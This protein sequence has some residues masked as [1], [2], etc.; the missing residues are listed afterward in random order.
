MKNTIRTLLLTI[1][2]GGLSLKYTAP[3]YAL[4]GA[5]PIAGLKL[6]TDMDAN[7]FAITNINR[8]ILITPDGP[9]DVVNL[10][11]GY[12]AMTNTTEFTYLVK[13]TTQNPMQVRVQGGATQQYS[14]GMYTY[15]VDVPGAY[16]EFKTATQGTTIKHPTYNITVGDS[17][18]DMREDKI[19]LAVQ[20][21]TLTL[22]TTKATLKAGGSTV[23]VSDE[24]ASIEAQNTI[25]LTTTANTGAVTITTS[26]LNIQT[27]AQRT[28]DIIGAN[29]DAGVDSKVASQGYARDT[30]VQAVIMAS[31]SVPSLVLVRGNANTGKAAIFRLKDNDIQLRNSDGTGLD[32]S[33]HNAILYGHTGVT[34][35]GGVRDVTIMSDA[36]N[37]MSPTFTVQGIDTDIHAAKKINLG[38]GGSTSNTY[39]TIESHVGITLVAKGTDNNITLDTQGE[40]VLKP[41]GGEGITLFGNIHAN[42]RVI[43]NLGNPTEAEDAIS[44]GYADAR[45]AKVSSVIVAMRGDVPASFLQDVYSVY[46]DGLEGETYGANAINQSRVYTTESAPNTV[47]T[48]PIIFNT[49]TQLVWC[50]KATGRVDRPH[51]NT[52]VTTKIPMFIPIFDFDKMDMTTF[53]TLPVAIK[54]TITDNNI[55]S[56]NTPTTILL[57]KTIAGNTYTSVRLSGNMD[58]QLKQPWITP[59]IQI[60]STGFANLT[61]TNK[62]YDVLAYQGSSTTG[63]VLR[64]RVRYQKA[65]GVSNIYTAAILHT[66]KSPS[67]KNHES[68]TNTITGVV[69]YGNNLWEDVPATAIITEACGDTFFYDRQAK[70][71]LFCPGDTD[72]TS[73]SYK[74][75][76]LVIGN[77]PE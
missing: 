41:G 77:L 75:E 10:T 31:N 19:D 16:S 34:I 7:N 54:L 2:L 18:Y 74:L 70:K 52:Q 40:I 64:L 76:T 1:T 37:I 62:E 29:S 65:L 26:A 3:V 48:M 49:S 67:F 46:G 20:T 55:M 57:S 45:Y 72:L 71:L 28:V 32:L 38:A 13:D 8:L 35:N 22:D 5:A 56:T 68:V 15:R 25:G 59:E 63:Q 47:S 73:F 36:C 44:R 39:A 43:H 21:T 66:T 60:N 12:L 9:M 4:L 58:L 24:T 6:E 17:T 69:V 33:A 23:D 11:D 14:T 27:T 30:F 42:N 50:V 51:L 61:I 53:G